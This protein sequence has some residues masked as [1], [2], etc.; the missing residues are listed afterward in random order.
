MISI[1][2]CSVNKKRLED[3]SK[4][5]SDTIGCEYELLSYDNNVLKQSIAQ[6]YNQ[7]IR[8][9]RYEY[10]LLAH[11]DMKFMTPNWGTLILE[12]LKEPDCGVIGFAGGKVMPDIPTGWDVGKQQ[13]V[14]HFYCNGTEYTFN[15]DKDYVQV[16]ALDGF[17][18]FVQ[19]KK[20]MAHPFDEKLLTGFHCYDVDFSLGINTV[21][22]NY[23]CTTIDVDHFSKGTFG[24]EWL[25]TTLR[26][27]EKKWHKMLPVAVNG[28][29]ITEEIKEIC[30]YRLIFH[31]LRIIKSK[32]LQQKFYWSF[33]FSFKPTQKH[34]SHCAS[35]GLKL[36]RNLLNC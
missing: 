18:M 26:M 24:T 2:V 1:I 25:L 32:P 7:G 36:L 11:E 13:C 29:D 8:D 28:I 6:V 30:A 31:V 20:A 22:K 5:V 34:L 10:L 19:R 3:F 12:K 14:T 17:A 4:N 33:V 9:A 27:Y 23:V 16:V 15:A 35:Q 21:A